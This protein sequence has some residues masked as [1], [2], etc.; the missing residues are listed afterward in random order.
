MIAA[1]QEQHDQLERRAESIISDIRGDME[2][3]GRAPEG[4][5][6]GYNIW[7]ERLNGKLWGLI[8]IG[9]LYQGTFSWADGRWE[10][11]YTDPHELQDEILRARG[12]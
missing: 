1:T 6:W 12:F 11:D 10:D 8:D 2:A 9:D 5:D 3:D 4:A 7:V